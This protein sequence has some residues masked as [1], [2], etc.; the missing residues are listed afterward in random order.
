MGCSSST[1]EGKNKPDIAQTQEQAGDEDP[2]GLFIQSMNIIKKKCATSCHLSPE[3]IQL[4]QYPFKAEGSYLM[5]AMID[6]FGSNLE[7]QLVQKEIVK[8]LI[9]AI[10]TEYMPPIEYEVAAPSDEEVAILRL[11]LEKNLPN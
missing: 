1:P 6:Q 8:E 2:Q 9:R 5:D 7:M 10:D 4:N 3:Y 11:W